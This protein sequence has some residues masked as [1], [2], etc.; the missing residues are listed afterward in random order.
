MSIWQGKTKLIGNKNT[1]SFLTKFWMKSRIKSTTINM[2]NSVTT[3]MTLRWWRLNMMLRQL[4]VTR[5]KNGNISMTLHRIY[6]GWL[7][8]L[9]QPRSIKIWLERKL[10]SSKRCSFRLKSWSRSKR[11][12]TVRRK[13]WRARCSYCRNKMQSCWH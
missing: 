13:I 12:W 5:Y 7:G 2:N 9:S 3:F 10:W 8:R 4:R 6:T 1:K 11:R